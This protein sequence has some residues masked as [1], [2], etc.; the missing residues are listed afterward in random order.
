MTGG[1]QAVLWLMAFAAFCYAA[2]RDAAD[3]Q[4]V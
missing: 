2:G 1:V 4:R 3:E